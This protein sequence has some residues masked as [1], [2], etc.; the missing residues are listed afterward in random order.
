MI[1]ASLVRRIVEASGLPKAR[2]CAES[3]VSRALLDSY[4]KGVTQPSL[5]QIERLAASAGLDVDVVLRSRPSTKRRV[6]EEFIAVLDFGDT[7]PRREPRPLH[8]LGPMWS[9]LRDAAD[10]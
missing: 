9:R 4:L 1:S 5:A 2:L 3:G 10:V 6:P 8:S 7:F